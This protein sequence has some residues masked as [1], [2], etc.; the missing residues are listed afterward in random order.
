MLLLLLLL[1]LLLGLGIPIGNENAPLPNKRQIDDPITAD[2]I[3]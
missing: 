3:P 2:R 1:L